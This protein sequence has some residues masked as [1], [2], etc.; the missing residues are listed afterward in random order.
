M[1]MFLE[2]ASLETCLA[3]DFGLTNLDVVIVAGEEHQYASFPSGTGEALP[4]A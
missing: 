4:P 3:V 2:G 1:V